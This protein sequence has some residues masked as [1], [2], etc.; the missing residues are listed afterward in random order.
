MADDAALLDRIRQHDT[1]ALAQ[2]YDEYYER[3][4]HYVYRYVGQVDAAED[5]TAN[6]FLRL[7]KAVQSGSCPRT[8]LSAWLYRVAHNLVVDTFRRKPVAELELADWLESSDGDLLQTVE[9]R[10][11]MERV[12]RAL[13]QL[14]PSQ[15]QVL[16]LRFLEGLDNR[17]IALIL[18]KSVGAVCAL[19]HRALLALRQVL[20]YDQNQG[21]GATPVSA[22]SGHDQEEMEQQ[23]LQERHRSCVAAPLITR[24]G[25]HFF[26]E[27]LPLLMAAIQ[28]EE[29]AS[30]AACEVMS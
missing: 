8:N 3:I 24:I 25:L 23:A 2:V 11:Q 26:L 19:Q 10:L 12:H 21:P 20:A 6:V 22:E 13:R 18:G 4:Y 27:A 17:E 16:V 28:G 29:G 14:T 5:L 9:Q 1:V 7:L 30:E 15:Q